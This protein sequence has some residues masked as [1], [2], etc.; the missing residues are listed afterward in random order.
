M[1]G[2]RTGATVY[3]PM[4]DQVFSGREGTFLTLPEHLEKGLKGSQTDE[5]C[6]HRRPKN[7][8]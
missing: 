8:I 7:I 2:L 3:R 1:T 6:A 4:A 5:F